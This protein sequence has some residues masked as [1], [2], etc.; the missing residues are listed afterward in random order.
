ML[1]TI[2][3]FTVHICIVLSICQ[4]NFGGLF[5]SFLEFF[6]YAFDYHTEFYD[7]KLFLSAAFFISLH[8]LLIC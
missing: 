4:Y 7:Y 5:S 1:R 8:A 2:L 6:F 3:Y